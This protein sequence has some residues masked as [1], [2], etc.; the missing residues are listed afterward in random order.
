MAKKALAVVKPPQNTAIAQVKTAYQG[1][2]LSAVGRAKLQ[3]MSDLM[4]YAAE[5][6][7]DA[8]RIR[9]IDDESDA[10]GKNILVNLRKARKAGEELQEF[11]TKPLEAAKKSVIATFRG[12]GTPAKEQ[13]DRLTKEA[14]A[15]FMA[16]IALQRRE[17]E[18]QES[19]Q[20]EAEEKAR[21]MGRSVPAPVQQEAPAPV[22]RVAQV[23]N[24]TVGQGTEF[25]PMFEKGVRLDIVP[26]Q[27]LKL[28][29]SAVRAAVK[30]GTHVIPG[31]IIEEVAKL[32]V[33]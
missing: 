22:E 4:E 31:I 28:D 19:A 9:I 15:L 20:R 26:R 13:E 5:Q 2:A 16:K 27:Y 32:A 24:G 23:D 8:C 18:A 7:S 3:E 30:S 29:E 1:I 10:K 21:R 11:F 12:L 17:K 25:R 33:R 14:G 6:T